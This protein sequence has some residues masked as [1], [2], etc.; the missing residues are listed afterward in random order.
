M[1]TSNSLYSDRTCKDVN[2]RIVAE[3]RIRKK[4][5]KKK[6]RKKEKV[7]GNRGINCDDGTLTDL[8]LL[9]GLDGV[10]CCC[11]LPVQ[12]EGTMI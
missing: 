7:I 8:S 10:V 12:G 4:D 2:E 11:I 6:R 9:M 3:Y 1:E 5:V